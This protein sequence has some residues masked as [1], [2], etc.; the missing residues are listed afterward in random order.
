MSEQPEEKKSAAELLADWRA[1]G[2]DVV[3]ARAGA[4]VAELALVAAA[5]AERAVDEVEQAAQ[6]ALHA[7]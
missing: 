6:A 1:A 5:E 3:A 7:V 4:R 2:R